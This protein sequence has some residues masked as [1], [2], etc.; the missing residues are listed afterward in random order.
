[1]QPS[2]VTKDLRLLYCALPVWSPAPTNDGVC[3]FVLRQ[4]SLA[5]AAMLRTMEEQKLNALSFSFVAVRRVPVITSF[6]LDDPDITVILCM[7]EISRGNFG[8]FEWL[9]WLAF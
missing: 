5:A 9:C 6:D 1:M 7:R 4:L 3:W 2:V 8:A